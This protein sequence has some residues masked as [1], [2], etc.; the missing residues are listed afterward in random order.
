MDEAKLEP[1]RN[2]ELDRWAFIPLFLDGDLRACLLGEGDRKL[3]PPDP[4]MSSSTSSDI[5]RRGNGELDA[6]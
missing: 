1:G 6:L 3:V 4:N 5:G 2:D